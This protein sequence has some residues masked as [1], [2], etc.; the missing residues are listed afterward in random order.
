MSG[1]LSPAWVRRLFVGDRRDKR[2]IIP[3]DLRP[4]LVES[5][6]VVG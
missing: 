2:P 3:T 6:V 5:S 4:E 1:M